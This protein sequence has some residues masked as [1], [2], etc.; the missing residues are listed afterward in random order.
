MTFNQI[1]DSDIKM[2]TLNTFS[3]FTLMNNADDFLK[4]KFLWLSEKHLVWLLGTINEN[5]LVL[6]WE[7]EWICRNETEL[8]GRRCVR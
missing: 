6:A 3:V 5:I 4:T 8:T 2:Q 7:S 1:H